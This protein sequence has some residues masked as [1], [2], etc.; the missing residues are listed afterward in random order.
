LRANKFVSDFDV[1]ATTTPELKPE[2]IYREYSYIGESLTQ[3]NTGTSLSHVLGQ[4]ELLYHANAFSASRDT[5]WII[6]KQK[7]KKKQSEM[8]G[9][10]FTHRVPCDHG[11]WY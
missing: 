1:I 5:L 11:Y 8:G 3:K 7:E 2:L 9:A 4:N 6:S 10:T